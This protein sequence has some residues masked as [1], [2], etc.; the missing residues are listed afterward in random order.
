MRMMEDI[1]VN[2]VWVVVD[3][4]TFCNMGNG[5]SGMEA[6]TSKDGAKIASKNI[7][8]GPC[9]VIEVPLKGDKARERA[10]IHQEYMKE[11]N[12]VK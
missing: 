1:E 4:N 12:N 8:D 5:L 6:Y 7:K 10:V 2:S 3:F 9:L 11:R